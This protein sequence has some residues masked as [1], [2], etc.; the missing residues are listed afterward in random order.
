MLAVKKRLDDSGIEYSTAKKSMS[1]AEICK[2]NAVPHAQWRPSCDWRL[3]IAEI[4]TCPAA[5]VATSKASSVAS[6]RPTSP[7][8]P[9]TSREIQHSKTLYSCI[10]YAKSAARG[11]PVSAAA[12]AAA[13]AAARAR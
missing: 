9:S 1:F 10:Q 11:A 5:N 8:E 7:C 12:T 4:A 2:A 13:A 3:K 6:Q